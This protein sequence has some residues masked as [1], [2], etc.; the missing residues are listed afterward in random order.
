MTATYN[1]TESERLIVEA[2][3]D[4]ARMTE[5][6]WEATGPD[7]SADDLDC[8]VDSP[9]HLVAD[10]SESRDPEADAAGIARTRNNLA[11]MADQ[12]EAARAEVEHWRAV[13][14]D[15]D[16]KAHRAQDEVTR[17][18][19]IALENAR[20]RDTALVDLASYAARIAAPLGLPA[21]ATQDEIA[22][23]VDM[24]VT[25]RDVARRKLGQIAKYADDLDTNGGPEDSGSGSY[26]YLAV[27][28]APQNIPT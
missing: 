2:R 28:K 11:A 22:E 19:A 16:G 20:S 13:A 24:V 17:C 1:P 21:T 26:V 12:L 23:A 25:E 14:V 4:D 10:A 18:S 7:D 3:E 5:A 8:M 15:L 9:D 6:P 27:T